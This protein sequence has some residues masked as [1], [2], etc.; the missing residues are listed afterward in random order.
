MVIFSEGLK[1]PPTP[2]SD[3]SKWHQNT[4]VCIFPNRDYDQNQADF[5]YPDRENFLLYFIP[6]KHRVNLWNQRL[7]LLYYPSRKCTYFLFSSVIFICTKVAKNNA[8][9][10]AVA[11]SRAKNWDLE[12]LAKTFS[13]KEIRNRQ[14]RRKTVTIFENFFPFFNPEELTWPNWFNVNT[15]QTWKVCSRF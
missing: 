3:A 9:K 4:D 12:C 15:A 5:S 13:L 1:S 10:Y 6:S 7:Q 8:C 2:T 11:H 14:Y